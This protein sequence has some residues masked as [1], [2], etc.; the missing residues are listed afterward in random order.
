M[1]KQNQFPFSTMRIPISNQRASV[2]NRIAGVSPFEPDAW[3]AYLQSVHDFWAEHGWLDG[4][5]AYLYTLDEPGPEG[6]KLVAQ[7]A[8]AGAPLLP[9]RADAR[10]QQPEPTNRFLWDD[11]TATTRTSGRCFR[12]ATTASRSAPARGSL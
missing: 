7:Q 10:H 4:H 2:G 9:G 6:M 5:L 3:C 11:R 12:A 1:V 8:A